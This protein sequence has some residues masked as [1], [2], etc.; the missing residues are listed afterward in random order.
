MSLAKRIV[1]FAIGISIGI[2]FVIII[3]DKKD[4]SFD[5]FPN[6]RVLKTLRTKKRVFDQKAL[7]FFKNKEIDTAQIELFLIDANVNFNKS[8]QH[9]EPCNFYQVE[10]MHNKNKIALY[11]KNCDTL[12]TVQDAFKI[13]QK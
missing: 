1:F 3:F 12:V 6:D 10:S 5:Y 2:V 4:V 8:Q 7:K 9:L 13:N 11:L